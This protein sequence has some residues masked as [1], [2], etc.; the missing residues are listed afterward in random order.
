MATVFYQ[1]WNFFFPCVFFFFES[2]SDSQHKIAFLIYYRD[3]AFKEIETVTKRRHWFPVRHVLVA[4]AT[5]LIACN[6][7]VF[8]EREHWIIL[9]C[10]HLGRGSARG[11]ERVKSDPR[12]R[13]TVWEMKEG[14]GERRGKYRPPIHPPFQP[15]SNTRTKFIIQCSPMKNACTVG[16]T[17]YSSN[18]NNNTLLLPI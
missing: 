1:I 3:W 16:Y 5:Q 13:M 6:A 7:G 14:E 11:L 2:F 10:C 9:R 8:L 18:N 4:C 17:T 15:P 12:E